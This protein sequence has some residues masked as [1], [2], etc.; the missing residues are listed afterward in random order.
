MVHLVKAQKVLPSAVVITDISALP[1]VELLKLADSSRSSQSAGQP[2]GGDA[3]KL[4]LF[5]FVPG[6]FHFDILLGGKPFAD[7][8]TC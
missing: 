1:D 5:Q 8:K 3:S 6:A 4:V 2:E 7:L